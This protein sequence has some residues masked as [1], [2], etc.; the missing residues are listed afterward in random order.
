LISIPGS[1]PPNHPISKRKPHSLFLPIT[2]MA[3][4]ALTP[5]S[6]P[7]IYPATRVQKFFE[8]YRLVVEAQAFK[9]PGL[10]T[11]YYSLPHTVIFHN[12]NGSAYHG[13]AQMWDWSSC[14]P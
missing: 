4:A 12:T 11:L 5:I 9:T 10:G 6:T 7:T 3:S 8:T 14:S 2:T 1:F 13:A